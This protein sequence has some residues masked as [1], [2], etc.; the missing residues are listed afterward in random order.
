MLPQREEHEH[1]LHILKQYWAHLVTN[2]PVKVIARFFLTCMQ[3]KHYSTH[4]LQYNAD[5]TLTVLSSDL[6]SATERNLL[7][8]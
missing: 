3:R 4:C 8:K 2:K 6:T 5:L 1:F 7:A